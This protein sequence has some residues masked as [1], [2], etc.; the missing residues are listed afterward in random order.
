LS[1]S[2]PRLNLA[3]D[4]PG[5]AWKN[6]ERFTKNVNTKS[7]LLSLILV[8]LLTG[9]SKAPSDANEHVVALPTYVVMGHRFMSSWLEVSFECKGPFEISPIKRAWISGV[10]ADSPVDKAGFKVGDNLLSMGGVSVRSMTGLT[11]PL[12]LKRERDEG[13][14]E[15]FVLQTPGKE[16]RTIVIIYS[17]D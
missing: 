17:K 13:E 8:A 9:A 12:A 2:G 10:K 15:A 4:S 16:E 14:K 1:S 11:L 6:N 3:G 7:V 5:R